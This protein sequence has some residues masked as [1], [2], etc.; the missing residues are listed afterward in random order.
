MNF[1]CYYLIVAFQQQIDYKYTR[2]RHEF[3][4]ILKKNLEGKIVLTSPN[5]V[6]LTRTF[7]TNYCL[8][9]FKLDQLKIFLCFTKNFLHSQKIMIWSVLRKSLLP[10]V[11][12]HHMNPRPYRHLKV[13][14]KLF[15]N[16]TL[17]WINKLVLL[18]PF[19]LLVRTN[20]TILLDV[21]VQA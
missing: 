10:F 4:Q 17:L 19:H 9:L 14:K 12:E 15:W 8:R 13:K 6:L 21:M 18:L 2:T 5:Y 7:S 3:N 11:A 20:P 16:F 1:L